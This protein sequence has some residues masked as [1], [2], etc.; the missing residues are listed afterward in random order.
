MNRTTL[1]VPAFLAAALLAGPA[2]YAQQAA[3]LAIDAPHAQLTMAQAVV[4]AESMGNGRATRARLE[5]RASQPVYNITVESD[6]KA[7]L[8]LEVAARDGR[9]VASQR[10]HHER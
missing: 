8:K 5:E 4:I 9:I 7:A 1:L 6:G 10:D 2:A 3:S